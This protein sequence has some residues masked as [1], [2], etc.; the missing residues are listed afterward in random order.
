MCGVIK[1]AVRAFGKDRSGGAAVMFGMVLVPVVGMM[2]AA[3]DYNRASQLR[4]RMAT[5]SDAAVLAAVKAT[6]ANFAERQRIADAVFRANLGTDP[7]LPA[8]NGRLL[9]I[10][11]N[12]Y[13]YE[14][15]GEYRYSVIQVL[16]GMGS[17]SQIAA[18][19]EAA[20][21][22]DSME[23]ALVL[24]TTGSMAADMPTLRQAASDFANALFNTSGP[25]ALRM[26]V[27]PYVAGVNPGRT[28][29]G[30]SSV[31][32]R[33]D[34][35]WHAVNLRGKQIA[36]IAGCNTNPF[37][38]PPVN[39]GPVGPPPPPPDFGTPGRGVWLQDAFRKF[40]A[41]GREVFGVSPAHAQVGQNGTP[42]RAAP[43]SGTTITVSP[44][45]TA[46][47]VQ[48]L[49]PT[50]FGNQNPC[51]LY[52]PPRMSNLDLFD[53]VR[54][55]NGPVRWK[56]CVEARPEPFD[57]TDEA[58]SVGNPNTLFVPYFWP[59][60]AGMAAG[61]LNAGGAVNNYMDDATVLPQGWQ[62]LGT[63]EGMQN[64]MKYDGADRG[65][66]IGQTAPATSGP[67]MACP[68]ELLRLNGN[69]NQVLSKIQSLSHWN[70]GGTISSEGLMWGWRTLSPRAPFADGAAY[71][72]QGN[73]KFLVLMTDGE[74][75]IGGGDLG[76]P[77]LSHYSAY[78]FL[79]GGRFPQE[80]F[81]RAREYLDGR[82]SAACTNAKSAGVTVITILFRVTA[83]A[84]QN[85][86]RS[87]ATNNMMFFVASDQNEL[88]RAFSDV[89]SLIGRVRLTR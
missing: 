81:Q 45:Y 40:A 3:V 39:P 63:W 41:V 55:A 13:R 80:N 61:G 25:N 77:F 30:M 79:R 78:G 72:T 12:G 22:D 62:L 50:G 9:R 58:P 36:S 69:R 6:G 8:V 67:N 21:G 73:K 88:R 66:I 23:V 87:C 71:G 7:N 16:P 59:D 56:G 11:A 4:A 46:A 20:A 86:L 68:D 48:A 27:V 32:A 85:L 54:G 26:S 60:E 75:E 51:L 17:G 31:D 19:A 5:A 1:R 42:N 49:V 52:N 38:T 35:Q 29:L 70:G 14:S 28:N 83:Q 2:G 64:I 34:G 37:W 76:G 53:G 74:N 15:S 84:S 89:A 57:V 18:F 33:G 47:P 24:D 65:A 43:W 10:G 44:P 82:L